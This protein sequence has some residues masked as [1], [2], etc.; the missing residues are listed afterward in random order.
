MKTNPTTTTS[1]G[2]LAMPTID[3]QHMSE[4]LALAQRGRGYVEPNPMVG[5]VVLDAAGNVVGRG[6]HR[7]YGEAHAEVN[8]FIEAGDRASGGTLYVTLEPCCHMGKTP[9]C[10]D[11]VL[12]AGVR[13]IVV[14]MADP[15]PQVNGGGLAQLRQAGLIVD[16]GVLENQVRAMM[17]PY[18][19]LISTARPWVIGKWAMS[20]DGKIAT[21][22][23]DS[24]WISNERSR[25]MV[26]ELRGR[27]D[28]I[29]VGAGTVRTDDPLLTARPVGARIAARVV[30]SGSG[31]LPDDCQ[32]F[33]TVGQ[34]PVIVFTHHPEKLSAWSAAGAEV[35]PF[36][37]IDD[38]LLN[39]GQRRFTNV[40]VEGG[41][42]LLG[43]LMDADAF[44]MVNVFI[45][46]VLLGG[47]VALS[48]LGGIGVNSVDLAKRF[49]AVCVEQLDGDTWIRARR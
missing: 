20:L 44:D 35:V 16:V 48:P 10:T 9:P 7:K 40:L 41:A 12:R 46:P 5:A 18:L 8:A 25:A 11:A 17:G 37:T 19:K 43:S 4:C 15:F 22:T 6:W 27:V 23:G 34:A 14:G 42:G 28:A 24:K 39:L 38:V 13:R 32:L 2:S 26:Q 36:D 31:N 29:I 33:R 30:V 45:A 47:S 49:P 21:S 1:T 3:E